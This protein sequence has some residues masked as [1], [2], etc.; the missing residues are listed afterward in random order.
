MCFALT[1]VL[2]CLRIDDALVVEGGDLF[3]AWD[4]MEEGNVILIVK[5]SEIPN[6]E[7]T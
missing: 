3:A 4:D 7:E 2:F 1:H 5:Y 6:K